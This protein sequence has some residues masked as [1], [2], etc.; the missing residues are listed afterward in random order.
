MGF[1]KSIGKVISGGVKALTGGFDIGDVVTPLI[2]GGLGY[3]GQDSANQANVNLASQTSAFNAAEAER[4]RQFNAQEARVS[5]RFNSSQAG[6]ARQFTSNLANTAHQREVRDL[7]AAGLNPILSSRLGGSD[8]PSGNQASGPAAG[9]GAASGVMARVENAA[10]QAASSAV[11]SQQARLN[12]KRLNQELKGMKLQNEKTVADTNL[13]KVA[14]HDYFAAIGQ[15]NMATAKDSSQININEY[16]AMKKLEEARGQYLNNQQ[17]EKQLRKMDQEY[18]FTAKQMQR[19]D[20]ELKG[21]AIEADIDDT[22]V[23]RAT[24]YLNRGLPSANTAKKVLSN[25]RR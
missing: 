15:K 1:F 16:E 13:S 22:W 7:R 6:L 12:T 23:G 24:R 4:M 8:T 11:A 9:G 2:T 25:P 20:Y 5:R 3:L 10:A 18:G 17:I 19:L 14:M 21:M